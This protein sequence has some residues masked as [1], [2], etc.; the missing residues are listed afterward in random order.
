[1]KQFQIF[2]L[3]LVLML[4]AISQAQKRDFQPITA[5]EL[6]RELNLNEEQQAQVAQ[7]LESYQKE[8]Q[9]IREVNSGDR[10]AMRTAYRDLGERRDQQILQILDKDQQ[11]KYR[12]YLESRPQPGS[13]PNPLWEAMKQ[14]LNLTPQQIEELQPIMAERQEEMAGL[15]QNRSGSRSSRMKEASAIDQKYDD[16]IKEILTDEQ[17]S[18]YQKIKQDQRGK[19]RQE[20]K[21]RG[22]RRQF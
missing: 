11:E 19:M 3:I 2:G 6:A 10:E 12:N 18:Q 13:R 7:I 14:Q 4:V 21:R 9:L 15:L 16:K 5:E 22:G 1:M 20:F 8:L 17:W